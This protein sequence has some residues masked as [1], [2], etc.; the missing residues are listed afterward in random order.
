MCL[1]LVGS[2]ALAAVSEGGGAVTDAVRSQ[3]E[4]L[5]PQVVAM[6]KAALGM[7]GDRQPAARLAGTF[8]IAVMQSYTV[9]LIYDRLCIFHFPRRKSAQA[10]R[11]CNRLSAVLQHSASA[12]HS[13]PLSHCHRPLPKNELCFS[14]FFSYFIFSCPQLF[15]SFTRMMVMAGLA[16]LEQWA[17][18]GLG[19][20]ELVKGGCL[21]P[22]AAALRRGLPEFEAGCETL[23]NPAFI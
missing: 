20:P 16:C 1:D 19:L 8:F 7:Q 6:C 10:S 23:P 22:L 11:A 5:R 21:E 3:L 15:T 4:A 14:F 2:I 13:G 12:K 17:G 9:E 18:I